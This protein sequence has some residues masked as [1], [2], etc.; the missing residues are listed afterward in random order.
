MVKMTE[1]IEEV[2]VLWKTSDGERFNSEKAAMFHE[3]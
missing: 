3:L 1:R 2:I